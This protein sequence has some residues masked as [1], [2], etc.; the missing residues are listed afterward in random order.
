VLSSTLSNSI[1]IHYLM[2]S[3]QPWDSITGNKEVRRGEIKISLPAK[4]IPTQTK[5]IC[6]FG[7]SVLVVRLAKHSVSREGRP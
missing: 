2:I 3:T 6:F 7:V 1:I 5:I 4:E